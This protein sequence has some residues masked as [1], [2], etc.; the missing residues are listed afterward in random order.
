MTQDFISPRAVRPRRGYVIEET[1]PE[2][3]A[4]QFNFSGWY[5]PFDRDDINSYWVATDLAMVERVVAKSQGAS[6]D[7]AMAICCYPGGP[8]YWYKEGELIAFD[9][10]REYPWLDRRRDVRLTRL[11]HDK[12]V[13]AA[14]QIREL[15]RLDI[16]DFVFRHKVN[17]LVPAGVGRLIK[18]DPEFTRRQVKGIWYV[19]PAPVPPLV[20]GVDLARP[21]PCSS[22]DPCGKPDV[23]CRQ[24]HKPN[25]PTVTNCWACGTSIS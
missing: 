25:C 13:V 22:S 11:A 19:A 17:T 15:M 24:C 14:D 18:Q 7:H 10:Y 6:L 4:W 20:Q 8:P 5:L 21:D 1:Y 3:P 2:L 16:V 9:V 12:A 23:L